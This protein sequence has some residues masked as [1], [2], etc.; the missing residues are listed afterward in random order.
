MEENIVSVQGKE[1]VIIKVSGRLHLEGYEGE[2]LIL[3]ANASDLKVQTDEDILRVSS[4]SDIYAKIP[5][6]FP[7]RVEKVGGHAEIRG[8]HCPDFY[9]QRVGG[10]LNIEDV[11]QLSISRVGG[12]C[13]VKHVSGLLNIERVSGHL[14]VLDAQQNLD[15]QSARGD[16]T[17]V[18]LNGSSTVSASGDVTMQ[19]QSEIQNAIN[20]RAKGD[21]SLFLPK[22]T[23]ANL[24][25]K[26]GGW[27]VI[28]TLNGKTDHYSGGAYQGR[29]GEGGPTIDLHAS[30]SIL[31]SD[32]D[33]KFREVESEDGHFNF[34][35]D[36]DFDFG[37]YHFSDEYIR[38]IEQK[39]NKAAKKMQ[40]ADA[41]M[42]EI[43][44]KFSEKQ[45]EIAE[46]IERRAI[47]RA[48]QAA[49]RA[50]LQVQKRIHEETVRNLEEVS[51]KLKDLNLPFNLPIPPIPTA[52]NIPPALMNIQKESEPAEKPK[53]KVS[54]QERVMILEM[55]KAG[56]ITIEQ[57]DALLASLEKS[58]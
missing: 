5:A 25:T 34:D 29:L 16:A 12:N 8:I 58:A 23:N 56:K 46:R 10:H 54:E 9:V 43:D 57:A 31:I 50:E 45:R 53:S 30:G 44:R 51:E 33:F 20:V 7:T 35:F 41:R 4:Y 3:Q 6:A 22:D 36:F 13:H 42:S 11:G 48:E 14:Y 32:E 39:L 55:L 19:Y 27:D 18:M 17:L 15:V 40:Q 28:M 1:L 49:R 37:D 24:S 2:D 26:F 47:Q 52:P 21:I 38:R